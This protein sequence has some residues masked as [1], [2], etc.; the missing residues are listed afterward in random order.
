MLCGVMR[1]GDHFT[2]FEHVGWEAWRIKI[3]FEQFAFTNV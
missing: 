3:G 1:G 2:R